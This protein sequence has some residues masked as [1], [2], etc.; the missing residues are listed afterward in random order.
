[1]GDRARADWKGEVVA[2]ANAYDEWNDVGMAFS[3]TTVAEYNPQAWALERVKEVQE[4][5]MIVR[6]RTELDLPRPVWW[7]DAHRRLSYV[8]TWYPRAMEFPREELPELP[9]RKTREGKHY[10]ALATALT[11]EDWLAEWTVDAEDALRYVVTIGR[12]CIGR[13]GWTKKDSK[14][15]NKLANCV[16][17]EVDACVWLD[18][19]LSASVVR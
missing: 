16:K 7:K 13:S 3:N 6:R 1:M 14:A 2:T 10:T 9:D 8:F 17:N 12:R 19:R 18:K 11:E 4:K 15:S 5:V